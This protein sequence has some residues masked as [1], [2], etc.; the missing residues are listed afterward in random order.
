MPIIL[1]WDGWG[2]V[3]QG[4]EKVEEVESDGFGVA[5]MR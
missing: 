2:V 1:P 3:D 4:G 5:I